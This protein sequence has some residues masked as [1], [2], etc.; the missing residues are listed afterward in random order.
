MIK[1]LGGVIL[2]CLTFI[3]ISP[4][5]AQDNT[6]L[7]QMH[8]ADQAARMQQPIDWSVLVKQDSLRRV[9]TYQLLDSGKVT[10]GK[11][12]YHAAMIFQHGVFGDTTSSAMAVKLMRKALEKDSS[13][14][15]WLLAAAI[16]RN[17][18]YSGRPQIYGTQYTAN[19]QNPKMHLYTIDSTQ[20]SDEERQYYHVGSVAEIREKER[21]MGLEPISK[22]YNA[23]QPIAN[24]I[25][26]I[27]SEHRKGKSSAYAVD[28]AAINSFGYSLLSANKNEDALAIFRLNTELYPDGYNTWDSLGEC[29]LQL[30]RKEEAIK[31]YERSVQLNPASQSGIDALKKLKGK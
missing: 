7:K 13:V 11:D 26:S 1:L 10:T 8:D 29:L 24:T 3:I 20:I 18:M 15:R 19:M 16:D 6:E 17:L 23:N 28:E 2:F 27:K 22:L 30:N 5:L 12:Y 14:N 31:A 9:R 21:Q 4:V 25:A